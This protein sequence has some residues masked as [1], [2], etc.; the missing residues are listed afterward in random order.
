MDFDLNINY[1]II[2]SALTNAM[3]IYLA[4]KVKMSAT[5]KSFS[6]S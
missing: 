3:D 5:M 4:E 1:K 6:F 2:E